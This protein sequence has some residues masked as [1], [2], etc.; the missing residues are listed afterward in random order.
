LQAT[1]MLEAVAVVIANFIADILLFHLDP[2][3]KL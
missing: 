1:F 2:R 3:V